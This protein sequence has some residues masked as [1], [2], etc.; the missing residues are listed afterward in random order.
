MKEKQCQNLF[1][2]YFPFWKDLSVSQQEQLCN[3]THHKVYN[4]GENIHGGNGECTGAVIVKSGC[5]RVYLLSDEGKEITLYRL[6][7]GEMCMLSASCVLE[8]ITFD[9][10]IDAEEDTEC[11]IINSKMFLELTEQNIYAKNFA[12]NM[13]VTR[14]SDVIWAMQ[15][16]MFKSFDK[17]LAQFLYDEIIRTG[18]NT[19]NLTQE[20]IAK[21]MSTAREVVSRMLKYFAAENI[22]K[23]ER[24]GVTI[25]D[26]EKLRKLA[27]N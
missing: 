1:K 22:V 16:I 25:I 7:K 12:L 13:A 23:V 24:G 10:F 2:E 5:M 18:D 19:I 6:Y 17:R 20:H 11:Y 14:F 3:N 21:Y 9:V 26:K 8:E 15:Q 27:I 4:K